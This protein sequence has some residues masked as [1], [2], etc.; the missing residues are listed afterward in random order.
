MAYHGTVGR[1]VIVVGLL[2]LSH[3]A[4]AN[5]TGGLRGGAYDS[6][7]PLPL[8]VREREW[9]FIAGDGGARTLYIDLSTTDLAFGYA[10]ERVLGSAPEAGEMGHRMWWVT[11]KG[12]GPDYPHVPGLDVVSRPERAAGASLTPEEL[13]VNTKIRIWSVKGAGETTVGP[14][15][16]VP[17]VERCLRL[18]TGQIGT[19]GSVHNEQVSASETE[20]LRVLKHPV[21]R[22]LRRSIVGDHSA[23][24]LIRATFLALRR[25]WWA[26]RHRQ[27]SLWKLRPGFEPG[28]D[29][30]RALVRPRWRDPRRGVS[31]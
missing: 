13:L 10:Y 22:R 8:R 21:F 12:L 14:I 26:P 18:M 23:S 6:N 3:P 2:G 24:P 30:A 7:A 29:L 25:P 5:P 20:M 16:G 15:E 17:L 11:P 27:R 28:L 1:L 31:R 19:D 4:V 9:Q